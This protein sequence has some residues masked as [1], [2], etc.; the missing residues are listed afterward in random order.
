MAKSIAKTHL[1]NP[2]IEE[3][4]NGEH[5]RTAHKSDPPRKTVQMYRP[6]KEGTSSA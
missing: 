6:N 2:S 3:S 5:L 4:R 1:R